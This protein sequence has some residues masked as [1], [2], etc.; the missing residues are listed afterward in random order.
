MELTIEIFV[1]DLRN[2]FESQRN[3]IEFD[4][5]CLWMQLFFFLVPYLQSPSFQPSGCVS[6]F[7][8]Y[9]CHICVSCNPS[10]WKLWY[11]KWNRKHSPAFISNPIGIQ[12]NSVKIQISSWGLLKNKD[13]DCQ[14]LWDIPLTLWQK[15]TE[16]WPRLKILDLNGNDSS[17]HYNKLQLQLNLSYIIG[18]RQTKLIDQM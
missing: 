2:W 14:F 4:L 13:F 7:A 12:R 8:S 11:C 16:F 10:G 6:V 5:D 1:F 17:K 9:S 18:L 3:C 15:L